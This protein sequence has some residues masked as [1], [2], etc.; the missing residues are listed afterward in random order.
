MI[1]LTLHIQ[2]GH[3]G[4]F[5]NIV[6]IVV[7][8]A[9]VNVAN[10]DAIEVTAE[11]LAQFLFRIAVRY[12]GCPALDERR[13]PTELTLIEAALLDELYTYAERAM[14]LSPSV[15]TSVLAYLV[16]RFGEIGA[17]YAIVRARVNNLPDDILD[18]ALDPLHEDAA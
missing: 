16:L 13:M 6:K 5:G 7:T 15:L 3:T 14:R 9:P 18:E 11:N 12:L 17:Q 4:S 2:Y 10:S 1:N 8:N